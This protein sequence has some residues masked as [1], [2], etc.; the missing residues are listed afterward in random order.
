MESSQVTGNLGRYE[1]RGVLGAG[2]MALVLDG[3]D[4]VIGRRVAIKTIRRDQLELPE[5]DEV[6]ERFKRE[7]QA[8][9]RLNH[10][11]IVSVYE[12]GEDQG[13]AYIAMEFITGKELKE[14]FDRNERFPIPTAMRIMS[15]ILGALDLAHRHGIV[16]RDIKPGNIYLLEDGHAKVADFGI[17]RME[18]SE[19]TQV[20]VSLGT[21]PY[22]SPEQFTGDT[23]DG[24]SDLFSAGVILYQFLTGE[25]PFTGTNASTIMHNVLELDPPPPSKLNA[26]V[27]PAFDAVLRK[28]LMKRRDDRFG[29]AREFADAL[30]AAAAGHAAQPATPAVSEPADGTVRTS[31][32]PAVGAAGT[33][34]RSNIGMSIAAGLGIGLAVLGVLWLYLQWTVSAPPPAPPALT[35]KETAPTPASTVV[36]KPFDPVHALERVFEARDRDHRV[37]VIPEKPRIQVGKERLRFRVSSG[38]PGYVYVLMVGTDRTQFHL[39][40]PNAVD[41]ENRIAAGQEMDLPRKGWAMTAGGP[42]G[43]D[44]FVAIVSENPRNF[45]A[46]GLRNV[47]PFGEFPPDVAAKLAA[48]AGSAPLFAGTPVCPKEPCSPRYGAA[49]F[50]IEEVD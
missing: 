37:S 46:A 6:V 33:G 25:R 12:Y 38:K 35:V 14:Y 48:Q 19:L 5:A 16:H 39:L 31:S 8:A 21:P 23:L 13:I 1:I 28:A 26:Q 50:S 10:P 9:G 20:G 22:M 49:I 44:H 42:S 40:F 45:S 36:P 32:R 4:P 11:N 27:P 29:T 43:T 3:W 2:A 41:G 15:E 18:S 30:N 17:A 34:R 24:R 7:A 47:D